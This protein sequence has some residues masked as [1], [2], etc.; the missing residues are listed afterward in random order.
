MNRGGK[1]CKIQI[2]FSYLDVIYDPEKVNNSLIKILD[3]AHYKGLTLKD[4]LFNFQICTYSVFSDIVT[5]KMETI[6]L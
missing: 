2:T 1:Q 3:S 6:C 4:K 5:M